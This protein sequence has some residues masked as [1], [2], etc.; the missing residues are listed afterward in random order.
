MFKQLPLPQH[1][2]PT[3]VGKVWRLSYQERFQEALSWAKVHEIEPASKDDLRICLILVDVQNTFC[4]PDFELF[5]AG[6][7][8]SGAIDDN[9]RLCEFIYKNIQIVSEIAPTMDTHK[10]MQIFHSIFLVDQAGNHPTPYAIISVDEIEAGNWIVN[11]DLAPTLGIDPDYANDHLRYYARTL[12]DRG[13]FNLTIWPYHAM[14]GGIGH[15]LVS[16]VEE[17]IFFHS[18]ARN[19]QPDFQIKGDAPLTEHYSALR[20]EVMDDQFG[21]EI[22]SRNEKFIEKIE[23]FDVVII[24]G[25]AK[26]HCV[27]FTLADLVSDIQAIDETL[28]SKVYLLEDCT[29]PVVIEGVVDYTEEADSAFQHFSSA[30]MHIVNST[31]PIESWPGVERS[32][33]SE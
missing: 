17:A 13:K 7:S 31:D 26:S 15:A 33:N 21:M 11:P 20:S 23:E 28:A 30:G 16:S 10:A 29:S 24:T 1:Y 32:Q 18:I 19:S 25:Q 9:R 4:I 8:G 2:D 12:A 22:G 27:A 14:L 5:V 3:K 6:R